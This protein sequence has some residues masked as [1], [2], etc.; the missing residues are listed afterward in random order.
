M[1]RT[2][3]SMTLVER[4]TERSVHFQRL[5]GPGAVFADDAARFA[6][7]LDG[8]SA[9]CRPVGCY[10]PGDVAAAGSCGKNALSC[11]PAAAGVAVNSGTGGADGHGPHPKQRKAMPAGYLRFRV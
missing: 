2:V 8:L 1:A 7:A 6:P 9:A 4:R 11:C 5:L 10:A 3:A